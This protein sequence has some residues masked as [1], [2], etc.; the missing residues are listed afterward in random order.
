MAILLEGRHVEL[1]VVCVRLESIVV[2]I[3]EGDVDEL[4]VM[5]FLVGVEHLAVAGDS[6]GDGDCG[7]SEACKAHGE[8]ADW[9]D[10]S[11][12]GQGY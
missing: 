10:V 8:V 6:G 2:A 3:G 9:V 4:V 5:D 7:S 11:L 1:G 12:T